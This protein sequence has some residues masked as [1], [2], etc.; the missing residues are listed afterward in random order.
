MPPCTE[1][2]SNYQ[3]STGSKKP[4]SPVDYRIVILVIVAFD[5]SF[6]FRLRFALAL[7][8]Y[9]YLVDDLPSRANTFPSPMM[10]AFFSVHITYIRRRR[11]KSLQIF[12]A[13]RLNFLMIPQMLSIRSSEYV[14]RNAARSF[15]AG[16][17]VHAYVRG[18]NAEPGDPGATE[19][20]HKAKANVPNVYNLGSSASELRPVSRILNPSTYYYLPYWN[21]YKYGYT[22]SFPPTAVLVL[23]NCFIVLSF[24]FSFFRFALD[25]SRFRLSL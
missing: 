8:L 21:T 25:W 5:V 20:S 3:S 24:S 16:N 10:C 18:T 7:L 2:G 15:R 13:A 22:L 14:S 11:Q 1:V 9:T 23:L 19:E 12:L 4:S 17:T 6:V